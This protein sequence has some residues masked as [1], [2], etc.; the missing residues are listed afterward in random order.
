MENQSF[1]NSQNYGSQVSVPN[2][3][4]VLVLGIISIV[5]CW[6]TGLVGI[7]CG[8]IALIMSGKGK[9]IYESSPESYTISS[10]NNMKAGKIC[11]IIGTIL[12]AIYLVYYVI[13]IAFYGFALTQLPWSQFQ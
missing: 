12:S 5:L 7:A 11:A 3:T 1:Q 6:C 4:A 10:F 8:I 9:A 13:L 2:S